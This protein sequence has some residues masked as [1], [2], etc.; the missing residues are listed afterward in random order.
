MTWL[1][2]LFSRDPDQAARIESAQRDQTEAAEILAQSRDVARRNRRHIER[3]H[4]TEGF[5]A[6]F[7]RR[8]A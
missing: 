2:K 1:S 6:A 7:E 8:H 3:N 5:A 4:I